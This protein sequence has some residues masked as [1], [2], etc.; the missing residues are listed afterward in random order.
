[1]VKNKHNHLPIVHSPYQSLLKIRYKSTLFK[2][3][4]GL[5]R[6]EESRYVHDKKI[7]FH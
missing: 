1:M 7:V 2:D 3:K 5:G 6:E 4:I